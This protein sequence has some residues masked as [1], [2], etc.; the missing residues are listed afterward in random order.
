MPC[1][2]LDLGGTKIEGVV[3]KSVADDLRLE[4][5]QEQLTESLLETLRADFRKYFYQAT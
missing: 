4:I 1:F 2:G 3:L 5:N